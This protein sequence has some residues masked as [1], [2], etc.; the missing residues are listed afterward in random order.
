MFNLHPWRRQLCDRCGRTIHVG[1]VRKPPWCYP[2]F[3][4]HS[5]AI[6]GWSATPKEIAK[7]VEWRKRCPAELDQLVKYRRLKPEYINLRKD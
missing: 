1:L 3:L 7:A 4:E 2:C 5:I 6:W